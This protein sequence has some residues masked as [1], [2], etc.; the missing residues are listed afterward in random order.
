MD[1]IVAERMEKEL[2]GQAIGGWTLGERIGHGKSALVFRAFR[3]TQEGAVKIFDRELVSK[4]GKDAQRERVLREKSLVGKRHP[5]LIDIL[6]AG[7]DTVHDVFFV[8]MALFH[9]KNLAEALPAVPYIRAHELIAQV[10]S[11]AHFLESLGLA[12]R[13]I[14]PENIGVSDDFSSAVLLDLGVLRP[15]GFSSITDQSGQLTFVGTLQYSPPELLYREEQDSVDGWRAVTFYQLGGVLHDLITHKQLFSE[16]LNPYGRLV[17]AVS[18]KTV[19]IQAP[20]VAPE[21][22]LLAQD[23]L[24]KDPSQRLQLVTW[25]R[26]EKRPASS[27]NIDE[28]KRR[29]EQRRR[30]AAV[31]IVSSATAPEELERQAVERFRNDIDR[32]LRD[33]CKQ[34]GLPPFMVLT[35]DSVV[36]RVRLVFGPSRAHQVTETFSVY[37]E[38]KVVDAVRS[39]VA[40]RAAAAVTAATHASILPPV[41]PSERLVE[42]FQGVRADDVL[43]ERLT[44]ALIVALDATQEL[45]AQGRVSEEPTWIP[46][47]MEGN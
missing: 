10:A 25:E 43:A 24:V 21:L 16:E 47:T 2:T 42:L 7:E 32:I 17:A 15:V 30:S 9:G 1:R 19:M 8:V 5:H 31:G 44:N 34:A 23:C 41:A 33:A 29:I 28:I 46:V 11:A 40:V 13:D 35:D 37:V 45:C 14:K 6:D 22:R 12:H 18:N 38:G 4:F 36:A 3:G 27:G 26:F 20:N 39:V